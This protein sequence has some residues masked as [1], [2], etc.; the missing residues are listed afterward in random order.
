MAYLLDTHVIIYALQ[1]NP[2]LSQKAQS[3]I[4][5]TENVIYYSPVSLW[6]IA[7]KKSLGKLELRYSVNA[8]AVELEQQDILAL[9][10]DVQSIEEVEHLSFPEE[11]RHRDPFDRF[12]IAQARIHNLII[13]SKDDKFKHYHVERLW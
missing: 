11:V 3:A 8:I 5:D 13:I 2:L 9:S 1:K 10:M 12:L 7:I 6:E 4:E